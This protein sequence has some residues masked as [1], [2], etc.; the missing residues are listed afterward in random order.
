MTYA[1][2]LY[3]AIF[4]GA[5]ELGWDGE[6]V[7]QFA[8]KKLTLKSPLASLK[9]LGPVQLKVLAEAGQLEVRTKRQRAVAL[10]AADPISG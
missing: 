2:D 4:A 3:R 7:Y 9:E 6:R 5:R 10:G 1:N 8:A